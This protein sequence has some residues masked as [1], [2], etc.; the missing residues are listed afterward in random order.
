MKCYRENNNYAW[1]YYLFHMWTNEKYQKEQQC[2]YSRR[3]CWPKEDLDVVV[4]GKIIIVFPSQVVPEISHEANADY[5]KYLD[6]R[7]E[8]K[9]CLRFIEFTWNFWE[10]GGVTPEELHFESFSLSLTAFLSHSKITLSP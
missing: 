5:L 10:G 6:R 7:I 1:T 4:F 2:C 9:T 3:C 8:H